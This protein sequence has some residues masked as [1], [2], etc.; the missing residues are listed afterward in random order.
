MSLINNQIIDFQL[1]HQKILDIYKSESDDVKKWEQISNVM[2]EQNDVPVKM[3]QT[4]IPQEMRPNIKLNYEIEF[5]QLQK[6]ISEESEPVVK[7]SLIIT[8]L[9]HI[10]YNLLDKE[11]NYQFIMDGKKE[12]Q[13][14]ANPITYYIS[15]YSKKEQNIHFHAFILQYALESLFIKH[16]YIGIDFEYT[17][18]KIQLAQLNFEHASDLRSIIMIISPNEL[19]PIMTEN[20]ITYIMCNKRIIKILHGADAKDLPY[21]YDHLLQGNPEKIIKFTKSMIDT[22]FLCEYYKLNKDEEIDNRCSIYNDEKYGSAVYYFGVISD[23]QQDKLAELLHSLP[24]PNEIQWY[25]KKLNTPQKYYAVYDVIYLKYFYY[26]I[27]NKA[28]RDEE[29]DF[30]KKA[31][32]MLYKHILNELTEFIYLERHSITLLLKQCKEEVNPVN[33]FFVRKNEEVIKLIDI[34]NQISPNITIANPRVNI[35]NIT[36]VTYYKS[37]TLIIIKRLVYG[38]ASKRCK[39]YKDKKSMWI[40]VLENQFIFDF[41]NDNKFNYLSKIFK[42]IENILISRIRTI[43]G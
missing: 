41:F 34:F 24:V 32:I 11:G 22:R 18:N 14:L 28:T 36:K 6:Q 39:I 4:L 23:Q 40:N 10:I 43:C 30:G 25:I 3:Y 38:I 16:F 37:P 8:S 21:V 7:S 20:F 27:I 17:D 29:T 1:F 12:M 35:E 31:I 19:E 26:Y 13:V 2:N 42:E 9:H 15:V 5:E 33:N